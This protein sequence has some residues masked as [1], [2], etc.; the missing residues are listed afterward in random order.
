VPHGGPS[1]TPSHTAPDRKAGGSIPS[2]RTICPVSGH[3]GLL[4]QDTVDRPATTETEVD[5]VGVE[6]QVAD[7]LSSGGDDSD[8]VVGDEEQHLAMAG[9]DADADMSEAAEVSKTR[10]TTTAASP[11]RPIPLAATA[12]RGTPPVLA[13]EV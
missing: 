7:Q 3:T 2:R 9:P 12:A 10:S 5:V 1:R 6:L 13:A 11:L 4:L 8:V